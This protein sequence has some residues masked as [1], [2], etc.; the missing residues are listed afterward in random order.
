MIKTFKTNKKK[1][2]DDF[3]KTCSSKGWRIISCHSGHADSDNY[4]LWTVDFEEG[5][6]NE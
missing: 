1:E 5:E 2:F 4:D 3:I 6:E